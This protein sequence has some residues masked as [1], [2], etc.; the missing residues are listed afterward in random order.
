ME[1]TQ[2]TTEI[3]V[4]IIYRKAVNE[5]IGYSAH[6]FDGRGPLAFAY[7]IEAQWGTHPDAGVT[8]GWHPPCVVTSYHR[9]WAPTHW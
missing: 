8:E 5:S 1:P 3:L 7:V 2:I 9:G 6:V 4:R